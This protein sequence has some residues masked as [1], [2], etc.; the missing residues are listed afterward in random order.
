VNLSASPAAFAG[1]V[2]TRPGLAARD[3]PVAAATTFT[4]EPFSGPSLPK[5]ARKGPAAGGARRRR[6][7]S[8]G[9]RL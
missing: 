8:P 9:G 4:D 5:T 6:A 7:A 2:R 3:R 1:S